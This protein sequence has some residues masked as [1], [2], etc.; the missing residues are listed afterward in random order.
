MNQHEPTRT[1]IKRVTLSLRNGESVSVDGP[2][3]ITAFVLGR[4][5]AQVN[6]D[7]PL[8]TQVWRKP[9]ESAKN[10]RPAIAI[11]RVT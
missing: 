3:T 8:S 4:N 2:A 7:A 6:V 5:R 1:D 10:P 9:K 11:A